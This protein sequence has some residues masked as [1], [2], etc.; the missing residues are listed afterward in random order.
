L[1]NIYNEGYFQGKQADGYGDYLKSETIIKKE[2]NSILSVIERN[3]GKTLGRNLL[4]IGCAMGFFL[5]L[6]KEKYTCRG[7]EVSDFAGKHCIS[8]GLDVH[9]GELT[10]KF[11][12]ESNHFDIAV[13]LDV[14]EHI[15]NPRETINLLYEFLNPGGILIITTGNIDSLNAKIFR[16][17][18]RLMTPPQHLFFFSKKTITELLE[19]AGFRVTEIKSPWKFVSFGLIFYQ[20]FNRLGLK[21]KFNFLNGVGIYLNLFDAIRVTAVK[22]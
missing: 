15:P 5:D 12:E 17:H 8:K 6:A 7:I 18:W 1:E 4:E 2:F 3:L 14:I 13:M 11:L 22:K 16:K 10:R 20:I 9:I 19:S 21:I